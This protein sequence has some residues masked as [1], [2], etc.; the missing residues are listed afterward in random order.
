MILKNYQKKKESKR[1]ITN[2]C[3]KAKMMVGSGRGNKKLPR[4]NL[5]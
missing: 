5:S 4:N 2:R 3:A 1:N